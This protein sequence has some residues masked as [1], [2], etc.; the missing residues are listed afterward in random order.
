[1]SR[2]WV[3][4]H[5][6]PH[7]PPKKNLTYFTFFSELEHSDNFS[8]T[9]LETLVI[10]IVFLVS[11]AANVGA[12]VLVTCERR[13]LANKTIL[14]LNLFVADLL[15]VSM[16]PLI[17]AVRWTV[18]W[19]LGYAACHTVLDVIC[20]S[21]CVAV[22]TLAT[23]SVERVQ[24]ILRLQTV[25]TLNPR[26]VTVTLI[27]TWAFS[28]LTSVPLSLFFTVMEVDF[29][30][31]ERLHIC[32]LKWHDAT[33]EIVW[34][35]AFTALCFLLPG[36]M[37]VVSYSKIL[38]IAKH[39]R[40]R[41]PPRDI[42]LPVGD[43]LD[44]QVSRQDLKLLRTMLV[45]L[46]SF[47]IMWSPIF[48]ITFLILA[49][50]M[51]G[52]ICVSSTMFFWVITF[53]LS[54]SAFNPILYSIC[55]FKSSWRK[56]CCPSI[57]GILEE[58]DTGPVAFAEVIGVVLD[59]DAPCAPAGIP[60]CPQT[61]FVTA[62]KSDGAL[63]GDKQERTARRLVAWPPGSSSGKETAAETLVHV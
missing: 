59:G 20:M 2:R 39:R 16:I 32:T 11:V 53:T 62:P 50:N 56:L 15:F 19:T 34:N 38:Q 4:D 58:F 14:T 13:L 37:I 63:G 3:E 61:A 28:A 55:Q 25:P 47:L 35:V 49:R 48:I 46:L 9:I 23:V 1:M 44:C 42:E 43:S 45:L 54:N 18:S 8:R 51:L 30:K 6:F 41:L 40:W 27:F 57:A 17:V 7:S 31:H 52:H 33:A 22:T 21:G 36:I 10:T 26:M 12:A 5:G 60:T 24:A 29:P